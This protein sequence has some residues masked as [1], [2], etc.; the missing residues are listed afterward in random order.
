MDSIACRLYSRS[1][2]NAIRVHET[3]IYALQK[4]CIRPSGISHSAA[5]GLLLSFLGI[6][7]CQDDTS[8]LLCQSQTDGKANPRV[9]ASH[10][11]S[12]P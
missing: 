7:G 12:L 4:I 1:D 9:A 3:G 6:S 11:C 10:Q 5:L 2:S 8:I